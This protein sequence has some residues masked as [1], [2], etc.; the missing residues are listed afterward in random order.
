MKMHTW[1]ETYAPLK[2]SIK[3][4]KAC[5]PLPQHP[6]DTLSLLGSESVIGPQLMAGEARLWDRAGRGPCGQWHHFSICHCVVWIMLSCFT[7]ATRSSHP[8]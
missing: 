8:D 5:T 3:R 1:E 4:W 6:L 2:M 7:I